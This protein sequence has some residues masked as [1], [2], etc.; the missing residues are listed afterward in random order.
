MRDLIRA[1]W[2]TAILGTIPIWNIGHAIASTGKVPSFSLAIKAE[3]DSVKAVSP[4]TIDVKLKNVS[5]HDTSLGMFYAG[6]NIE[7][8][9]KIQIAQGDTK[10][11]ETAWGRRIMGHATKDD[12]DSD[13]SSAIV[14][15]KDVNIALKPGG[16]YAY[17]L[18]ISRIYDLSQPGKYT[19]QLQ[20]LDDENETLV[21]SNKITVT[22]TP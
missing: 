7:L 17:S 21:V 14:T 16:I 4:V 13:P 3:A 19:V 12:L 8:S 15:G 5:D 9:G 18:A 6:P 20:R 10:V 1:A 2:I 22:V 11:L